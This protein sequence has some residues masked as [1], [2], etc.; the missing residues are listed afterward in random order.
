M[1]FKDKKKKKEHSDKSGKKEIKVDSD[2][3]KTAKAY[4]TQFKDEDFQ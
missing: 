2:L 4:L 3:L 1:T